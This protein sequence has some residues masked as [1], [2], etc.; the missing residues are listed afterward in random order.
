MLLHAQV[1]GAKVALGYGKALQR[2]ELKAP[3]HSML[4]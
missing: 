4:W 3:S 2:K 1:A